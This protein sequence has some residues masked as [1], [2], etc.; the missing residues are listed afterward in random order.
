[1]CFIGE[2]QSSDNFRVKLS[3]GRRPQVHEPKIR[4]I[5]KAREK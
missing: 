3:N 1:M 2:L 5:K 4:A